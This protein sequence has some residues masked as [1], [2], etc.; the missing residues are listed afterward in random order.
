MN[1]Q[2]RLDVGQVVRVGA[3]I[4]T[5][6]LV[7]PGIVPGV[8]CMYLLLD[9]SGALVFKAIEGVGMFQISHAE[10]ID[11]IER[12][13]AVAFQEASR[14][15]AHARESSRLAAW[16]NCRLSELRA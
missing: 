16:I 14:A 9:A 15:I 6:R 7:V 1:Q 13:S 4:L 8:P 5:V 3:L 11:L 2:Q 10:A 12:S